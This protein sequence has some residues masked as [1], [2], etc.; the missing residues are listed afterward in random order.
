MNSAKELS[1]LNQN[2]C[3]QTAAVKTLPAIDFFC[4]AFF[5]S[6]LPSTH[7]QQAISRRLV[8]VHKKVAFRKRP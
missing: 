8:A 4:T 3:T 2:S 7:Y 5:S 6:A 1:P